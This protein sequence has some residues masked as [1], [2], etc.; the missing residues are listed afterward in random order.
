MMLNQNSRPVDFV[1][2]SCPSCEKVVRIPVTAFTSQ[3]R[4]HVRCPICDESFELASVL[5]KMIPAVE[6]IDNSKP[7]AKVKTPGRINAIDTPELFH[8]AKADHEPITA[9]KNGRFIVP[10]LLSKGIKKKKKR[11]RRRSRSSEEDARLA[12]SL[13]KLKANTSTTSL[14][15]AADFQDQPTGHD[16]HSS[17][18]R[19][20]K[21]SIRSSGSDSRQKSRS[22]RSRG[23]RKSSI[24]RIPTPSIMGIRSVAD[25]REFLHASKS[26]VK[27]WF[28]PAS[29]R[30]SNAKTTSH[31]EVLLVAIGA[32]FAIPVLQLMMWW[33]IG[34]DPLG[35]AKP[36]SHVAPFFVPRELRTTGSVEIDIEPVEPSKQSNVEDRQFQQPVSRTP[37]GKLPKPRLDPSSVHSGNFSE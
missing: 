4:S 35:L 13:A 11:S 9:K 3:S 1:L 26:L 24:E 21:L 15:S 2:G 34:I 32:M 29:S 30:A 27:S 36:T 19:N 33:F 16:D 8:I 18:S 6:V 28:R 17:Q 31:S 7:V 5:E 25:F 22:G 37:D 12:E 10:E 23:A 14:L 20:S